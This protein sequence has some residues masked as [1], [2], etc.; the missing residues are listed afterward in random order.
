MYSW[1][2]IK[3]IRLKAWKW[4]DFF[5]INKTLIEDLND[6]NNEVY[7]VKVISSL[8]LKFINFFYSIYCSQII[9][10]VEFQLITNLIFLKKLQSHDYENFL[11][12][13]T[14][15]IMNWECENRRNQEKLRI[16]A[17]KLNVEMKLIKNTIKLI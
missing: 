4:N 10:Y 8:I 2:K 13:F 11:Q 6:I 5:K 9:D 12:I 1:W 3:L 14:C 17:M 16:K 15:Q 7:I